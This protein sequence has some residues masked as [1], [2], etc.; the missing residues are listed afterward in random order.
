MSQRKMDKWK[1]LWLSKKKREKFSNGSRVHGTQVSWSDQGIQQ[2]IDFLARRLELSA[3]HFEEQ[4]S[5]SSSTVGL[6]PILQV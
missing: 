3:E 6:S 4:F 5:W 1:R 2:I